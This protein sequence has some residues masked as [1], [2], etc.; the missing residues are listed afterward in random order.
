MSINQSKTSSTSYTREKE[1][2]K[3]TK[4]SNKILF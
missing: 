4:A 1:R 2:N 3:E